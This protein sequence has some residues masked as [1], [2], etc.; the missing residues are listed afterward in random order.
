MDMLEKA[1]VEFSRKARIR[2]VFQLLALNPAKITDQRCILHRAQYFQ[3]FFQF[4]S[5]PG[6]YLWRLREQSAQGKRMQDISDVRFPGFDVVAE[7]HNQRY[8]LAH[9]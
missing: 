6:I 9:W 3:L 5:L 8:A 4:Y 2:N 7:H 1:I